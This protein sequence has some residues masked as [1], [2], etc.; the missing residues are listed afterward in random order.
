M[1][2]PV[3]CPAMYVGTSF[4][5]IPWSVTASPRVTAGLMW[6]P[7]NRPT[8]Y[9]ATATARPHPKVMT[10]HPEFC[11]LVLFNTTPATTPS[12]NRISSPVPIASAV[13]L[14]MTTPFSRRQGKQPGPPRLGRHLD[15]GGRHHARRPPPPRP[16]AEGAGELLR[17]AALDGRGRP[18]RALL[19][20]GRRPR[21]PRRRPGGRRDHGREGEEAPRGE[22][23]ARAPLPARREG[24]RGREGA[25]ARGQGGRRRR[26][27]RHGAHAGA[28]GGRG[29]RGR[30]RPL[31]R[32][33]PGPLRAR[34]PEARALRRPPQHAQR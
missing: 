6:A 10:I 34:P 31:R 11:D 28:A 18:R 15:P 5:A 1:L 23:A 32:G 7:L 4:H 20:P 13:K 22:G 24:G 29:R 17:A 3:Y 14:F 12:P 27:R 33:L 26:P 2:A 30:S 25:Q 21:R 8:A 16:R 19:E 9:T